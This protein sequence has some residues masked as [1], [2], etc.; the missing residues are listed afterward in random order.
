[1]AK[2]QGS[3]YWYTAACESFRDGPLN[4]VCLTA[5]F[6]VGGNRSTSIST[7]DKLRDN[8]DPQWFQR[9]S[10]LRLTHRQSMSGGAGALA[11]PASAWPPADLRRRSDGRSRPPAHPPTP[12]LRPKTC[13]PTQ[14]AAGAYT[15][16]CAL[17]HGD[18]VR[19]VADGQGDALGGRHETLPAT[20]VAARGE[21]RSAQVRRRWISRTI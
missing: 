19:S 3:E 2:F 1:M 17:D 6:S 16:V 10:R 18:V 12:Q 4:D 15:N 8:S 5:H 13:R 20:A 7:A 9:C 14:P 11:A 21:K